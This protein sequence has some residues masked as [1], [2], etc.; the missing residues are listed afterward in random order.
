MSVD[1]RVKDAFMEMLEE[2]ELG[3][4]SDS[5]KDA[6]PGDDYAK[7]VVIIN[8]LLSKNLLERGQAA[9]GE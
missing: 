7:L 5:L 2:S 8:E 6:F 1:E 3:V 4:P 9:Q